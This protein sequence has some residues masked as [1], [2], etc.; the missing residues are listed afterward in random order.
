MNFVE[1][2]NEWIR[3]INLRGTDIVT[4]YFNPTVDAVTGLPTAPANRTQT[5]EFEPAW[6]NANMANNKFF[7]DAVQISAHN[8]NTNFGDMRFGTTFASVVPGMVV[9]DEPCDCLDCTCDVCECDD[10]CEC[11]VLSGDTALASLAVSV[12]TLNPAFAYDVFDYTVSVENSVTSIDIVAVA[13]CDKAVISGDTGTQTLNVGANTFVITVTAE[14]GNTQDYT[15][16]VTRA[17]DPGTP[18][19]PGLIIEDGYIIGLAYAPE[20]NVLVP[21]LIIAVFDNVKLDR[22]ILFDAA[23]VIDDSGAYPV[24]M[25]DTAIPLSAIGNG[26]TLR[27]FVWNDVTAMIPATLTSLAFPA[28]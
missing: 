6:L 10:A 16:V 3:V 26:E 28:L 15:I 19:T 25:L 20:G 18:I 4:V 1:K 22:V 27:A 14:D 17:D 2:F 8:G 21:T 13:N 24:I 11:P 12:G 9:I 23:A 7:F 5:F